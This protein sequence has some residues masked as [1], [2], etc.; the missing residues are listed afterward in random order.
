MLFILLFLLTTICL[1]HGRNEKGSWC[2]SEV[3]LEV[4]WG[5][6]T[7]IYAIFSKWYCLFRQIASRF[8]QSDSR[9]MRPV[10]YFI[11][12]HSSCSPSQNN[13]VPSEINGL[14]FALVIQTNLTSSM[15]LSDDGVDNVDETYVGDK[16]VI[17]LAVNVYILTK[18]D[19]LMCQGWGLMPFQV[20]LPS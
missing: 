11:W 14:N 16:F 20:I 19:E 10:L 18:D 4:I 7:C 9:D 2:I 6:L 8:L 12:I 15:L 3:N 1:I 5:H 13:D 17:Y